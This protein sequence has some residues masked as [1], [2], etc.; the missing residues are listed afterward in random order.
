MFGALPIPYKSA[1]L[2]LAGELGCRIRSLTPWT[3]GAMF[4]S[5]RPRWQKDAGAVSVS[6]AGELGCNYCHL[7]SPHSVP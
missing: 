5:Q 6:M 1:P 7:C 4:S 2:L 3:A